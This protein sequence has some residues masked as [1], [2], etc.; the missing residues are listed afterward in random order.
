MWKVICNGMTFEFHTEVAAKSMVR[1]HQ[2]KS[3]KCQ[4]E[5]E[6]ID[7]GKPCIYNDCPYLYLSDKKDDSQ[8]VYRRDM[9]SYG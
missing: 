5:H 1:D 7:D 2:R 9:S 6:I 8:F 3:P 4:T